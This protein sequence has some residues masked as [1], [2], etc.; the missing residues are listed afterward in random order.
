MKRPII[1]TEFGAK[2][3]TNIRQRYLNT[4]I[5][6]CVKFCPSEDVA[7][8]MV[9]KRQR[10]SRGGG[11][12]GFFAAHGVPLFQALDEER[13]VYERSSSKNIYLNVAVNTLKKLRSKTS[14]CPS[15]VTSTWLRHASA[16]LPER[17]LLPTRLRMWLGNLELV[18]QRSRA[19]WPTG[20]LSLTSKFSGVVSP[21]RPASLSTGWGNS[22][23]RSSLVGTAS[24]FLHS[25]YVF[26][27][28]ASSLC[29]YFNSALNICFLCSE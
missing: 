5:D 10:G 29:P 6:E 26:T 9:G 14:S 25:V 20:G 19:L 8:Q 17:R 24:P 2:I 11:G 12:C 4:F 7:F 16:A 23:R 15:P 28:V 3:P 18:P 21:L 22:R 27:V 13:L 1:P